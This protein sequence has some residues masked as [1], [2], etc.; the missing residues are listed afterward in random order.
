M[1]NQVDVLAVMDRAIDGLPYLIED[2]LEIARAAV[3]ELIKADSEYD[4]SE[5]AL[6]AH[7]VSIFKQ[8][9]AW[10]DAQTGLEARADS[11][12]ARRA[13]A[14]AKVTGEK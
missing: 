6:V 5:D 11:A 14:L 10:R 8:D 2:E 9:K 13:A 12:I 3:A 7:H 1:S 4:A